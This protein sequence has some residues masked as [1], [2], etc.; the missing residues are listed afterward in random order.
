MFGEGRSQ[1]TNGITVALGR[2]SKQKKKVGRG[3]WLRSSSGATP[4]GCPSRLPVRA[5]RSGEH[6]SGS[7]IL[8]S[9]L[10]HSMLDADV[11]FTQR[12]EQTDLSRLDVELEF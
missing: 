7:I 1:G 12:I 8:G 4:V 5:R 6:D 2:W 11:Q 9:A 10:L 3:F